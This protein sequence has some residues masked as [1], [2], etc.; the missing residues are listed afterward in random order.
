MAQRSWVRAAPL[1]NYLTLLETR[2]KARLQNRV[3]VLVY[4]ARAR[5]AAEAELREHE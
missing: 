2:L 3:Q 4:A 5:P 1:Q